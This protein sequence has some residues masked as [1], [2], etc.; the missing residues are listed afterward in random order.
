M[1]SVLNIK[2]KERRY[3][4]KDRFSALEILELRGNLQNKS[5]KKKNHN[6]LLK[7]HCHIEILKH[8]VQDLDKMWP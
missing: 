3:G 5:S 8:E 2:Q 7:Q 6:I 1:S 4:P